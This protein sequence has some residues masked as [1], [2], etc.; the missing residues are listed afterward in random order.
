MNF[1]SKNDPGRG[2]GSGLSEIDTGL[3]VRHEISR[4]FAPYIGSESRT[5]ER[6]V[7]RHFH[8]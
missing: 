7:N 3:S 1:Y 6:L 2:A 8:S 5:P 4:K